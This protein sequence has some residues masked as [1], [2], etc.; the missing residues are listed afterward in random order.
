MEQIKANDGSRDTLRLTERQQRALLAYLDAQCNA[1]LELDD[2]RVEQRFD[3]SGQSVVIRIGQPGGTSATYI[4]RPRNLSR[5]GM[6]FLHGSF[7]YPGSVC[8]V[9]IPTCDSDRAALSGKIVRC[10]HVRANVHEVGMQFD[11]PIEL[12]R[13]VRPGILTDGEEAQPSQQLPKLTGKCL[14]VDP[15]TDTR[16][17]FDF[18]AVHLG[19][20]AVT[21]LD[22]PSAKAMV[23]TQDF[24]VAL[25]DYDLASTVSPS[26]VSDL[27]GAGYEGPIVA[28]VLS[29]QAEDEMAKLEALG[30][31]GRVVKPLNFDRLLAGLSPHLSRDW[32]GQRNGEPLFSEHWSKKAMQPLILGHLERLEYRLADVHRALKEQDI[33]KAG[34]VLREIA[35]SAGGF[36]YPQISDAAVRL[37]QAL[38]EGGTAEQ[39]RSSFDQLAELCAA[40]CQVRKRR[41]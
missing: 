22:G 35:G 9:A 36:G 41:A 25:V 17:L 40:A 26:L 33:V 32:R 21:T 24:D 37:V 31:T 16:E 23:A 3:F 7:C 27:R 19:L 29:H 18:I 1:D 15:S 4:V 34:R 8:E 10:R 38:E 6:G 5:T 2:Q 13:F 30:F 20:T 12:S 14:L 11:H 28:L 39:C